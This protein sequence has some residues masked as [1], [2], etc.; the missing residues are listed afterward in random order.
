VAY[1]KLAKFSTDLL[2]DDEW[3]VADVEKFAGGKT[4]KP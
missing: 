2:I 1:A 3:S 4:F